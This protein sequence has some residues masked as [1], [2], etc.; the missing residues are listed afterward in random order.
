[1]D[2]ES[3]PEGFINEA[4]NVESPM[5]NIASDLSKSSLDSGSAK[6]RHFPRSKGMS[7]NYPVDAKGLSCLSEI[8]FDNEIMC[9]EIL[10]K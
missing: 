8:K 10:L 2:K 1:M 9:E 7:Q 6:K 5:S 3:S 4:P